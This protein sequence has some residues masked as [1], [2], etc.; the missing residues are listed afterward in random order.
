ILCL[1]NIF[2]RTTK[3]LCKMRK[4]S[5]L[6]FLI[7][8]TC[9]STASAQK[10]AIYNP[11]TDEYNRAL[12]L[13]KNQQYL[14]A[15]ILFDRVKTQTQNTDIEA[16]CAYY[17]ANCAIRLEQP[18][19]DTKMENFVADYPT[20][21]KQNQA[22]A[23]VA[24]FYFSQGRYPQALEWFDKVDESSLSKNDTDKFNFQK[25]Y[26]YFAAKDQK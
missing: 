19:A 11:D 15:Q 2:V 12:M 26:S 8:I 24:Q 4:I 5:C 20:S 25:G 3:M 1:R 23:E 14:S 18:N 7:V 13:Y 21:T 10:S 16:D 9:F 6:L 17:S 22:F